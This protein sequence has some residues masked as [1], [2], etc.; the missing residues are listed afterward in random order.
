MSHGDE[1]ELTLKALAFATLWAAL[2]VEDPDS[3]PD[4]SEMAVIL[5]RMAPSDDELKRLTDW[6]A[7]RLQ[8]AA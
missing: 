4:W 7:Q 2:N 8:S 3:D 1:R 5:G 6:A